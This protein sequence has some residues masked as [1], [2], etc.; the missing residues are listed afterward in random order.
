MF[1][2]LVADHNKNLL[3]IKESE[4]VRKFQRNALLVFGGHFG[5]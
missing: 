2:G 3:K 5:L 1:L 4:Q